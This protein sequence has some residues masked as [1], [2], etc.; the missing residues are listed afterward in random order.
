VEEY[1]TARQA[2]DDNI[3]RR[4]RF[5]CWITKATDTHSE[6]VILIAFTQQ[7]WLRERAS[8]SHYT[9]IACLVLVLKV[10]AHQ[11]WVVTQPLIPWIWQLCTME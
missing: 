5:A 9:Y 2:T 3:I 7:Q 1:G 6:Y 10:R 8:M 11:L 4:M